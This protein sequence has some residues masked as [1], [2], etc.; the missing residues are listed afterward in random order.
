MAITE[1]GTQKSIFRNAN[2]PW[3]E[4]FANLGTFLAEIPDDDTAA[5]TVSP[6]ELLIPIATTGNDANVP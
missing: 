3:A 2:V 6:T 1:F 4:V 5:A